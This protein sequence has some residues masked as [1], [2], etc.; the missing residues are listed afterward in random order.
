M[1]EKSGIIS[2]SAMGLVSELTPKIQIFVSLGIKD[3]KRTL[4]ATQILNFKF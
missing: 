3:T 1:G 2:H 4:L